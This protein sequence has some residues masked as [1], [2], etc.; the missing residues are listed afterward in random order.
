MFAPAGREDAPYPGPIEPTIMS[1]PGRFDFPGGET[2]EAKLVDRPGDLDAGSDMLQYAD[3]DAIEETV[4]LRNRVDGD[5]FQ[6]LGMDTETRLKDLF[7]N[8]GV[9]KSWREGVPIM[10]CE[11]GIA[12][13]AGLRIA[14]WARVT[15][16][17]KRVL[18]ISL[19]T[20][21]RK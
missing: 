8:S 5:R 15:P 11:R 6:P 21:D 1:V 16:E 20:P 9:P 17:T 19:A 12:W 2:V 3:A 18:R 14:E 13:I 4:T 7:V 10:E